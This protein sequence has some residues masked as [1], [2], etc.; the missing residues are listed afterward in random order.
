MQEKSATKLH[1]GNG[2]TDECVTNSTRIHKS[3][4]N[5]RE[6]KKLFYAKCVYCVCDPKMSLWLAPCVEI[7][8]YQWLKPFKWWYSSID[9]AYTKLYCTTKIIFYLLSM[10]QFKA[11][12]ILSITQYYSHYVFTNVQLFL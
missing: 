1:G 3:P 4:I 8:S 6:W 10:K 11:T 2:K 7:S 12:T 5:G 9:H